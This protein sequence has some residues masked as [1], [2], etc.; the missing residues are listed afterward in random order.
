VLERRGLT[1]V[2]LS[3]LSEI[4]EKV[5][6]PRWVDLSYPLGFPLGEPANPGL[7]RRIIEAALDLLTHDGE[8]PIRLSMS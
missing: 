1:T 3:C 6:P 4:T 2:V 5:R 7:Q 8:P